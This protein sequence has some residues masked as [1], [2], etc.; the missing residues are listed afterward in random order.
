MNYQVFLNLEIIAALHLV[1]SLQIP[2]DD[3]AKWL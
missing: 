2:R 3:A 1:Y